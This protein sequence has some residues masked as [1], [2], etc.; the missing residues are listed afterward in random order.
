MNTRSDHGATASPAFNA[1]ASIF[2]AIAIFAQE[3][4]WNFYD[5]QVPASL[6]QYVSSAAVIG[7]LMGMDNFL[8]IFI[9]P[10]IAHRSD[11]T[12]SR[13]G[14]R[15]PYLLIGAPI[16]AMFYVAI[17]WANSFP[18]L[19]AS[20]FG[21]ALIANSFKAI[22]ESLTAD[23]QPPQHRSKGNAVA[24]IGGALTILGSAAVSYLVVDKDVHWAFLIPATL[25]CGGFALAWLG[26][27][28]Q[29]TMEADAL[30]P[31]GDARQPRL[32]ELLTDI[33]RDSNKSRLLMLV[34]VFLGAGT[35]SGMRSQMTPYAMEVL[36][37]TRGQAGALG[38]PA[39]IAFVLCAYPVAM[40][41]DASSR[42]MVCKLGMAVFALGC[43]G[44][45]IG[46]SALSTMVML[47]VA[48]IGYVGFVVNAIVIM[49]NF[50]PNPN[51]L[52]AYT[53]FYSL[54][55]ALGSTLM[56]SLLG[57]LVD[58]S[59]WHYMMLHAAVLALATVLL[60]HRVKP[61]KET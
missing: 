35:W 43:V 20:M 33:V 17:P 12:R 57:L 42:L 24:K 44:T 27:R 60:L 22:A 48:S 2:I 34:A 40:L 47:A 1:R 46:T 18:A 39:G 15:F 31:A 58:V 10:W 55:A 13:W 36:G 41:S 23:Y 8:G 53:G 56:P 54:A 52:G 61:G 28:S 38:L 45:F 14:R 16:A 32:R 9:Q 11:Q 21:F 5:A 19:V 50:S 29:K 3:S 4:V 49:W 51:T 7:L 26:L 37:L 59:A 6:R 30:V 25:L